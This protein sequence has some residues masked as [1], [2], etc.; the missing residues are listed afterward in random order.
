M[1]VYVAFLLVLSKRVTWP[2]VVM[3][4]VSPENDNSYP[5]FKKRHLLPAANIWQFDVPDVKKNKHE[6]CVLVSY[7]DVNV[8]NYVL[9]CLCTAL[10]P[11][12]A[13]FFIICKHLCF[14]VGK[15]GPAW[16]LFCLTRI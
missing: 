2:Q 11:F 15:K 14:Q 9:F 13:K 4:F 6:N 3:N 7:Y 1:L 12:W 8:I 16:V 5:D 10:P